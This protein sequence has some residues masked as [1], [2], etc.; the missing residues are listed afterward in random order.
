MKIFKK[1]LIAFLCLI[2]VFAVAAAVA[3]GIY[4]PRYVRQKHPREIG[5]TPETGRLTLV[6]SNVRTLT[7][8]DLG[9]KSW[10]YR[11]DLLMKNLEAI[12]TADVI[13][14]Q[15][16]TKVH[17]KY[18]CESLPGYDSVI[19]YRDNS[20]LAEGCPVFYNTQKFELTDKGSFWL[21]ETPDVMSRGWDAAFNRVCSYV[22]LREKATGKEL[23][24]FNVHLDHKGSEARVNSIKLI[25]EKIKA[26]GGQPCVIMGDLN[27][28]EKSDTYKTAT[29]LFD[30]A[31]YL[32]PVSRGPGATYHNW[33]QDMAHENLDYFLISKTGIT[34]LEYKI[35]SAALG[36]PDAYPSDHFPISLK[37]TLD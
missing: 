14:F 7:P 11:A 9:K 33:G 23:V 37:I 36:D 10:F 30:D 21:S 12:G 29:A 8:F 5:F 26:F 28:S 31:K 35:D 27:C 13:G 17:Y 25:L 24:V 6:S 19:T 32:A 34:P 2:L 15:E 3:V 4:Y 20:P 18:L 1:I 16:V 22:I